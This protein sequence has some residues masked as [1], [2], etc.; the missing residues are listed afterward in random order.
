VRMPSN[1]YSP[2]RRPLKL[3]SI[4]SRDPP[5]TSQRMLGSDQEYVIERRGRQPVYVYD[6]Y[7]MVSVY[8]K[9]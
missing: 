2:T 3:T 8:I 9:N 5:I 1:D 6:D 7:P 4:V